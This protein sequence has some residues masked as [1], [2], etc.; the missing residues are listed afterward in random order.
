MSAGELAWFKSTYSS[1]GDGDCVEVANRPGT[2]HVRGSKDKEGAR[3]ALSP[4]ARADFL[5]HVTK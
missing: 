2:V 4:T 1:G 3:F 5:T